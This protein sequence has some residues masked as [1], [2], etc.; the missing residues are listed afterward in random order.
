MVTEGATERRIWMGTALYA[1]RVHL[2]R[3]TFLFQVVSAAGEKFILGNSTFD[4]KLVST[5][6]SLLPDTYTVKDH[7][8]ALAMTPTCVPAKPCVSSLVCWTI[9]SI[10]RKKLAWIHFKKRSISNPSNTHTQGAL[11]QV[12]KLDGA[13]DAGVLAKATCSAN[14][15]T[16]ASQ[17]ITRILAQAV[18]SGPQLPNSQDILHVCISVQCQS[19]AK[20]L[21]SMSVGFSSVP[22]LSTSSSLFSA[23]F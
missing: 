22:T 19:L 15:L 10:S 16:L 9:P 11:L 20:N 6:F 8:N 21:V 7:G 13:V 17:S 18:L 12:R 23:A 1:D 14:S 4:E 5:F 3:N 2:Q